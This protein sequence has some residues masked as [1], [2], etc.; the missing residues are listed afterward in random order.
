MTVAPNALIVTGSHN[1]AG[2]ARM[3]A[4]AAEMSAQPYAL[5]SIL[6]VYRDGKFEAFEEK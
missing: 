3:R 6:F 1:R 4:M 2:L 5:T